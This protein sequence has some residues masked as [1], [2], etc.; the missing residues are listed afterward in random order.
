MS[1]K[2]LA[3]RRF[4]VRHRGVIGYL[5]LAFVVFY[6]YH[7]NQNTAASNHAVAAKAAKLAKANQALVLQVKRA[8]ALGVR[9]HTGVCRLRDDLQ[10]RVERSEA[11]LRA[12][13]HGIPG[14]P[15]KTI[16]TSITGQKRTIRAL[17]VIGPCPP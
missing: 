13:P 7:A 1:P 2:R 16:Q 12:N 14:L 10:T 3:T 17:R 8:A 15:A 9:T 5:I 11:F 4:W 6:L